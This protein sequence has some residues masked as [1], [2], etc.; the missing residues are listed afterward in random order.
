MK[1]GSLRTV[2][3]VWNGA[4]L[5]GLLGL[6]GVGLVLWNQEQAMRG[7]D[8]DLDHQARDAARLDRPPPPPPPRDDPEEGGDHRP[9]FAEANRA[10]D[11][12]RPRVY[13]LDGR[14]MAENDR[15]P[16]FD[17]EAITG[18][19][20]GRS[21]YTT[22]DY[23][24]RPVRVLTRAVVRDGRLWGVVQVAR[25]MMDV[26]MMWQAQ[27][28]SLALFIPLGVAAAAG[29]AF[30]LTNRA[31][32]PVAKMTRAAAQIS[33]SDLSQRLE[34]QGDDEM[35][36]LARTFNAML[37]R[38][39]TSF[40]ELQTAYERQQRFT[41]DASHE[42]RTPLTRLKLATSAALREATS[43]DEMREALRTAD[44]AAEAMTRLV[45]QLLMLARS[46][47]G[48]LP[49]RKQPVDLR[50]V[51]AEALDEVPSGRQFDAMFAEGAVEVMGDAEH[52]KRVFLNLLENADRHTPLNGR[53]AIS[54]VKREGMGI[55]V[56]EDTGEG[57]APEHLVHLFERFYRVD[58]ARTRK[59]GGSGLGLAIC[60]NLVEAHG[61]RLLV[62]SKLGVGT[63]FR[64]VFPLFLSARETQ[65]ISS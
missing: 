2:L 17:P 15:A 55:V 35:A 14:P 25:E 61:G 58:A 52:L 46:D 1:R 51:V 26:N 32:R 5:A 6:F 57:I 43:P 28:R 8:D 40:N 65:T 62:E 19:L 48:E 16:S 63:T 33:T 30:V 39:E 45:Q 56:V 49:L 37:T 22:V 53:V 41:A 47:A 59:D 54:V 12:R 18:A 31:L 50:V 38:L 21:G 4:T 23:D 11:V 36:E 64:A 3:T 44:R 42:L 34:V 10:F 27:L 13:G 29:G 20:A 60:R 7:L 24:G 9:A